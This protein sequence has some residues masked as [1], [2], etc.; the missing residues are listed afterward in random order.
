MLPLVQ[1]ADVESQVAVGRHPVVGGSHSSNARGSTIDCCGLLPNL[2]I[3]QLDSCRRPA[4]V[5]AVTN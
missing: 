1:V 3:N 4:A 2:G 5:E